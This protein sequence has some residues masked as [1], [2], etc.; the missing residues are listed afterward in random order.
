VALEAR[1]LAEDPRRD[2]LPTPGPLL[3]YQEPSGEGVRVD[4]GVAQGDRIPAQY[5][6]MIAKLAVWGPDRATAAARLGEALEAFTILGCTTNLPLLQGICRHPDFIRGQV[7]TAWIQDH[8]PELNAP[9]VPAPCLA[10]VTSRGFLEALS[11][12]LRGVGR[13]APGPAERFAT[14]ADPELG[15]GARRAPAALRIRPEARPHRFTLDGPAV[16]CM[17]DAIRKDPGSAHQ[18]GP[19]LRRALG[20]GLAAP[21]GFSAAQVGR[22]ELALALF[23]ETLVLEDPTAHLAAPPGAPAQGGGPVLAPMAGKVLEVHAAAGDA[24]ALGQVL[25]VLESMK[26]QFEIRAP[27]PGRVAAVLVRAGQNLQGPEPLA[28]LE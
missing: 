24:V 9:L 2:W 23:G 6:S 25:F 20:L 13:P 15:I 28:L 7:S 11:C 22:S 3:V 27:G 16:Q 17:L 14:L 4:S 21:L 5:D 10:L 8:L 1:I 18:R 12:S 26:M 19:G